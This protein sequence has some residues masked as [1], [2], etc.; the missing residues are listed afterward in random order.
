MKPT[1]LHALETV[2]P[3]L[4]VDE[5]YEFLTLVYEQQLR[6]TI[7]PDDHVDVISLVPSDLARH[8]VV[9]RFLRNLV[10]KDTSATDAQLAERAAAAFNIFA[11]DT[12]QSPP[13]LLEAAQKA[14]DSSPIIVEVQR[15]IWNHETRLGPA[16]VAT[17][18]AYVKA[19]ITDTTLER[20]SVELAVNGHAFTVRYNEC[21]VSALEI[22]AR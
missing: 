12:N 22:M 2:F 1:T 15:F 18:P 16:R 21:P 10:I 8:D 14:L 6:Q 5:A 3:G 11:A 19:F 4:S 9:A 7:F 20:I 17:G 13:E